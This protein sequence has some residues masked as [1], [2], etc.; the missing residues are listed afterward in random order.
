MDTTPEPIPEPTPELFWISG[1]PPAWRV[2]LALHL[3][4]IAY[5]SRRLFTETRDNREPD[6]LALNARG[7]V[8][9]LVYG[10]LVVTESVAIL[11]FLDRAWLERPLFGTTPGGAGREWS[12]VMDM[13]G[14]LL[15]AMGEVAQTLFRG[16]VEA[17]R[18]ALEEASVKAAEELD[19]LSR[20]LGEAP[21]LGGAVPMASD[22]HLLPT[23]AWLDRALEL[24]TAALP[25]PTAALAS[26]PANLAAWQRRMETLPEVAQTWPPHWV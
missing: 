26:R 20:H 7:Q 5:T 21:F 16:Q 8:P 4:G 3:K 23:L 14:N 11:A 9:T 25:A 18:G 6:Y 15:P 12:R 13:E 1:S 24:N 2:M 19:T 10:D 17:R 22:V